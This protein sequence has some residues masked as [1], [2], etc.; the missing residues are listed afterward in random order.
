MVQIMNSG[1]ED[2]VVEIIKRI[3]DVCGNED[4]ESVKQYTKYEHYD[5]DAVFVKASKKGGET[6]TWDESNIVGDEVIDFESYPDYP[7]N[8]MTG[9]KLSFS[10][11]NREYVNMWRT[12]CNA[13]YGPV[14]NN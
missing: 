13:K 6:N 11:Y 10:T 12:Y 3:C 2:L 8:E 7:D 9:K 1:R 5:N 14:Y 4:Q